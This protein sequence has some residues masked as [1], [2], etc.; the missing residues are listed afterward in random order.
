MDCRC[1]SVPERRDRFPRSWSRSP[2]MI[3]LFRACLRVALTLIPIVPP[4]L[5][6]CPLAKMIASDA[7]PDD[8]LGNAVSLQGDIA[9]LGAPFRDTGGVTDSGA[10]Y[11]FRRSAFE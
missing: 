3:Q 11:V 1:F 7:A 4:A 9:F 6:Q 5:S 2:P 8:F 10:V